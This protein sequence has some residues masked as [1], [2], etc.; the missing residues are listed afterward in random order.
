MAIQATEGKVEM[1]D[2]D[3]WE[4]D[5]L[6][7]MVSHDL[8]NQQQAALGFLELLASSEGLTE[9]ERAL[10]GRTVEVL[11]HT[12][13]LTLQ[14]RTAMVTRDMGDFHPVRVPLGQALESAARSVQGAFARN[15]LSIHVS[16]IDGNP[17]VMADGMLTEM[18]TQLM[19]LLSDQL[20]VDRECSMTVEAVPR[21]TV[22]AL[23][24]SSE[25]F[26]LNPMVVD[27]LT[28]GR[29]PLGR[30]TEVA[31]LVLVRQILLQYAAAARVE[32]APPGKVGA[33]LVIELPNGEGPDAVDNDS[34]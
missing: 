24:F 16:G 23:R 20:P 12:A 30:N 21:G 22:T 8:I 31:T 6:L 7:Q 34:R 10:V 17:Q 13:R 25:G 29:E 9:N 19:M 14:V 1:T 2:E 32:D 26:A 5:N 28:G 3:E 11:E 15:R 27:S 33:H 4:A 18:L